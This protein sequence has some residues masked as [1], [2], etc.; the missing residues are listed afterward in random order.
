[1]DLNHALDDLLAANAFHFISGLQVHGD[2]V[3]SRRDGVVQLFDFGEGRFEAVPLRFVLFA[4]F[5]AGEGVCEG[6][7]VG[8]ELELLE[9]GFA[10]K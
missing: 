8:P 7:S 9:G 6:G 1:M 10:C 2:W 3:P 5:S 4:A